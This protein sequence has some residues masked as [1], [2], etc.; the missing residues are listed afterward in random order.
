MLAQGKTGPD[1]G[2][3]GEK[4]SIE[5]FNGKLRDELLAREVIDTLLVANVLIERWRKASNTVRPHSPPGAALVERN[6]SR[7]WGQVSGEPLTIR[8]YGLRVLRGK[9]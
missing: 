3:P 4:V 8:E 7:P 5:S 6:W 2:S 1:P 9:R